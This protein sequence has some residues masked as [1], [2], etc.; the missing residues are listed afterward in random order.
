M[1]D[2]QY[3]TIHLDYLITFYFDLVIFSNTDINTDITDF[4]LDNNVG[5]CFYGLNDLDNMI[6]EIKNKR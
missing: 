4:I 3:L 6:S 5:N 2:F 1:K